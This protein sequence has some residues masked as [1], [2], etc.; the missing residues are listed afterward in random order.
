MFKEWC[1]NENNTVI[2]PGYCVAGTLGNKLLSGVKQITIDKKNYDVKMRVTNI[3]F[4]AHADAK[5]ILNLLRH[6]E[7][8]N[9]VFV[10]G[11]KAKMK[12][13][14]E[15]VS[16]Q[17]KRDVFMP[18]NFDCCKIK[19]KVPPV[20]VQAQVNEGIG[21]VLRFNQVNRFVMEEDLLK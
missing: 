5:G 13:F 2:I 1:G 9:I 14:S 15:V 6:L 8:E 10:H 16:E 19:V 7:P 12:V 3:S 17:L 20:E 18:A 4:S 21:Y 11:D